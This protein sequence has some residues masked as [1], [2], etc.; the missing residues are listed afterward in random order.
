MVGLIGKTRVGEDE[1]GNVYYA[2]G[3]DTDGQSAPL[4]DLCGANDASRVP[5]EWFSWLHHQIDD[6]PDRALPPQRGWEKPAVPNHDRHRA[7]LSPARRARE[8]RQ[9]RARDRRLRSL[10][11]R[12]MKLAPQLRRQRRCWPAS[13][14]RDG[15]LQ[16]VSGQ[17]RPRRSSR[18]RPHRARRGNVAG[19]AEVDRRSGDPIQPATPGTTPMK[20]RVAVLGL[21]NKRNGQS[22]AT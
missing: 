7:R 4:G 20:D 9:A 6:V 13:A 12:R 8:G 17:Q 11:A 22:R 18:P 16:L 2:G 14:R 19:G 15:R 3:K 5:P 10:D 1:L 21:L